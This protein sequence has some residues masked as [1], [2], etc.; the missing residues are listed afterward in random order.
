MQNETV[1]QGDLSQLS[2][3]D[4]DT[5]SLHDLVRHRCLLQDIETLTENIVFK[6][7]A[8]ARSQPNNNASREGC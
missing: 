2:N 5:S 1:R 6:E 4:Q 7:P 8:K 3:L